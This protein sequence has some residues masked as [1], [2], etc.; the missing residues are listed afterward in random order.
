MK[1]VGELRDQI[2]QN[3]KRIKNRIALQ[4]LVI[5]SDL[6]RKQNDDEDYKLLSDAEWMQV[7]LI[8]TVLQIQEPRHLRSL[9]TI[10]VTFLQK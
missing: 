6:L 4:K 2:G 3:A 7:L 10:A 9:K 8:N 1:K 5:I